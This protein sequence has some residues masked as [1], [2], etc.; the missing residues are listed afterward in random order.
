MAGGFKEIPAATAMVALRADA[1]GDTFN[2]PF[3]LQLTLTD[4][5]SG[6]HHD[7]LYT[8]N[9]HGELKP[10][11]AAL[12]ADFQQPTTQEFDLGGHA[13]SVTIAPTTVRLP[14]LDSNGEAT[15]GARVAVAAP[16]MDTPEPGTLLLG[17]LGLAGFAVRRFVRRR[18][19]A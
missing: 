6:E 18:N 11:S 1:A 2:A 13:Y 19:P 9:V 10:G 8:A 16:I 4:D 7:F 5:A 3:H 12:F 17:G 15:I 14:T